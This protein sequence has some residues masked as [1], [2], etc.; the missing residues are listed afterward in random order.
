M[1]T[2][3]IE[4]TPYEQQ[5]RR[6]AQ[7]L[8]SVNNKFIYG[9]LKS[10]KRGSLYLEKWENCVEKEKEGAKLMVEE[11]KVLYSTCFWADHDRTPFN[12]E[13]LNNIL[14]VK[15][16]IPPTKTDSNG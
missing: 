12:E 15:G 3:N 16:L 6:I 2:Q 11:M 4:Q 14:K 7:I 8:A 1:S 5:V 10:N 9:R 13:W